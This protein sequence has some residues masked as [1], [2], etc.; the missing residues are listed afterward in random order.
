MCEVQDESWQQKTELILKGNINSTL[1][2]L[3]GNKSLSLQFYFYPIGVKKKKEKWPHE[4]GV[5]TSSNDL[6]NKDSQLHVLTAASV[7]GI[8]PMCS[9]LNN[10]DMEGFFSI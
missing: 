1:K 6:I 5:Q 7:A 4:S 3:L 9:M 2:G 10:D 8:D